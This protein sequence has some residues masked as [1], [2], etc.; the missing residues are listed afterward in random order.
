MELEFY[1]V[2]VISSLVSVEFK[3]LNE[4]EKKAYHDEHEG[5]QRVH[6]EHDG[7]ILDFFSLWSSGTSW[8]GFKFLI[9]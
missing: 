1:V 7:S 4:I 6:D 5:M 8:L 3:D 2:V 9:F